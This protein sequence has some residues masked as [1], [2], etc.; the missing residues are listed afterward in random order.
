M[1]IDGSYD[2]RYCL[3]VV[4]YLVITVF[5]STRNQYEGNEA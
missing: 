2:S 4:A 5:F 1:R 3:T